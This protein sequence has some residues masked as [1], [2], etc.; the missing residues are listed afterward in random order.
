MNQMSRKSIHWTVKLGLAL[1]VGAGVFSLAIASGIFWFLPTQAEIFGRPADAEA[2]PQPPPRQVRE[3]RDI[4]SKDRAKIY[5]ALNELVGA[6]PYD[7]RFCRN[8]GTSGG[9]TT[10]SNLFGGKNRNDF[11]GEILRAYLVRI[12]NEPGSKTLLREI[13]D[14][15]LARARA[16]TEPSAEDTLD[17]FRFYSRVARVGFELK[18]R[19]TEFELLTDRLAHVIAL[20][21]LVLERPDFKDDPKLQAFCRKLEDLRTVTDRPGLEAERDELASLLAGFGVDPQRREKLMPSRWTDLDGLVR[22]A[23][24]G[25][26]R[27]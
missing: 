14:Y 6:D 12:L 20:E 9:D 21:R 16:G 23:F 10:L 4:P 22:S 8:L 7:A 17:K 1:V 26:V 5:A 24:R 27:F 25:R 11:M 2:A 19:Q 3:I 15:E 13:V 18:L